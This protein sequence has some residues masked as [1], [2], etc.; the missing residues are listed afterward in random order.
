MK[1][2]F[3][4]AVV[5]LLCALNVLYAQVTPGKKPGTGG[6]GSVI[7]TA[8]QLTVTGSTVSLPAKIVL[9]GDI[10]A[11]GRPNVDVKAFA[12]LGDGSSDDITPFTN[13][14]AAAKNLGSISGTPQ[15]AELFIPCGS[16]FISTPI[17]LPRSTSNTL[18]NQVVNLR[19]ESK[20]CVTITGTAG[21]PTG[22]ALIEWDQSA[23]NRT[24]SQTIQG[25]TFVEPAV[26]GV[27]S[28][29]YQYTPT[30]S[31]ASALNATNER[32][33]RLTLRDIEF[34]GS[35]GFNP[36]HFYLEGDCFNCT[37][38]NVYWDDA[39]A[40]GGAFAGANNVY[41][42][43][44]IKTDTCY[45]STA[46]S[47]E[48]CGFLDGRI[49]NVGHIG[50]RGGYT[51][52]FQ[53]RLNR[54]VMESA[55]CNGVRGGLSNSHCYEITN[56]YQAV[57]TN[58]S[59]E[60]LGGA[61]EIQC[62]N[63]VQLKF[64]NVGIGA[65]NNQGFGIGD[66]MDF[67]GC[68]QNQFW[69]SSANSSAQNA[70][71]VQQVIS[72][73]TGLSG[74]TGCSVAPTWVSSGGSATQNASGRTTISA[75]VV[76]TM[77]ID[78]GGNFQ[79][80]PTI[81]FTGTG[82]SG[83]SVTPVLTGAGT[84]YMLKLD[85]N[86]HQNV[87]W[88]LHQ[89]GT[90]DVSFSDTT[91][92]FAQ[93]CDQTSSA[94][95]VYTTLGKIPA[96]SLG[97]PKVDS[98]ANFVGATGVDNVPQTLTSTPTSGSPNAPVYTVDGIVPNPQTGT[99]YTVAATDR[100]KYVS[101]SNASAIAV[102]LPQAGTT[103]FA[104]NFVFSAC[105]IGT[106]TATITPTTSTISVSNG[107]TYTS[108]A[109][110]LALTTGLCATI[111][112]DNTN[113]FAVLHAAPQPAASY[114]LLPFVTNSTTGSVST[115]QTRCTN[116]VNNQ[117][118]ITATHIAFEITTPQAATHAGVTIY[119]ADGLTKIAD[120]GAQDSS[121]A[122]VKTATISSFTLNFG[123]EYRTCMTADGATP[124]TFRTANSSNILLNNVTVAAIGTAANAGAA[125]VTPTTTGAI[126]GS[127][128]A[129]V[130]LVIVY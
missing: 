118:N 110:T 95:S 126:T 69:S 40:S 54:G 92:N 22:R 44:G 115:N 127:A 15:S 17:I 61:A 29:H 74:G 32:L 113:Y 26:D 43:I 2:K 112:S 75:G 97:A 125:G 37:L 77:I 51:E 86:S 12:A 53:G 14:I 114:V 122:T 28:I 117:A 108:A 36:Y 76:Q 105:D 21:F 6:G 59:T 90:A 85:S 25:I 62:T 42:T 99:T 27:G 35:N 23:S 24:M 38:E 71:N 128:T 48:T 98:L 94:C 83:Q 52:L 3:L 18:S 81:V 64:Y 124:P 50:N 39:R 116:A 129:N 111:Y 57:F 107:K 65:P 100:A 10:H 84:L 11:N 130:A 56:S 5:V 16:Y 13:A 106:G 68:S 45:T 103:G 19:G 41:E 119:S 63:S 80:T 58:I 49:I 55:F 33:E 30:N 93:T 70:F 82:C 120:S 31:P 78:I 4:K 20:H 121:T 8:N 73:F 109:S 34:R 79:G 66:G 1:I 60:G 102:T 88:D 47:N 101:F 46:P 67:V 87:F 91:T 96:V 123:T 89:T 104:G 72:S 7:G 9:P